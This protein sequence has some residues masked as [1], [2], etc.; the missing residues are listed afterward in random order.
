[1]KAKAIVYTSN[2]GF[3]KAYAELLGEKI[4]LPVYDL[5]KG[6]EN[7]EK[8]SEIIYLGWLMASEIKGLKKARKYFNPVIICGVGMGTTGSQIEEMKK[9]NHLSDDMPLF[10]LQGG[11]DMNKLTGIYRLMMA[12]M[13]KTAGKALM[14]KGDKTAEECDMLDMMMNGGS[15]VSEKNLAGIMNFISMGD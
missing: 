8:G 2:S 11:F 6:I 4:H 13:K 3:T 7:L 10:S 1:M 5:P 9:R 12:V 15:R 14:N